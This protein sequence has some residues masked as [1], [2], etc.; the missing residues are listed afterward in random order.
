MP[1]K[2]P[3]AMRLPEELLTLLRGASTCYLTTIMPDGSPQLTQTWV[4]TDGEH[5]LINTVEHFQKVRNV[6]R[7]PRVALAVFEPAHPRQYYTVRGHVIGSADDE[8]G[9]H[10][11]ALSLRYFGRPYPGGPGQI[12]MILTIAAD[13]VH[14][15]GWMF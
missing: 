13:R 3:S 8:G 4:D 7:D 12:R 10:L 14:T 6:E 1:E 2:E 15:A 11:E 5:I 9:E